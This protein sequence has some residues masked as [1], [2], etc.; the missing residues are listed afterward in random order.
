MGSFSYARKDVG[1]YWNSIMK[2]Q[3]MPEA[4][5]DLF[6]DQDPPSLT[7]STKQDRFVRNFDVEPNVIIYHSHSQPEGENSHKPSVHDHHEELQEPAKQITR[8]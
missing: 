1:E 3:P 7:A 2:D 5:G 6:H 4:I 8:D